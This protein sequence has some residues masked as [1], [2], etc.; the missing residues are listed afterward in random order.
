LEMGGVG[1]GQPNSGEFLALKYCSREKQKKS[2]VSKK[3]KRRKSVD[4]EFL[5]HDRIRKK[6]QGNTS[7]RGKSF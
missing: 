1:F 4:Q 2:V 6:Y 3:R 7:L 5:A